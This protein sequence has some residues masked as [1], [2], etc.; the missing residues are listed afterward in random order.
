MMTFREATREVRSSL[1]EEV[2]RVKTEVEKNL[3][4]AETPGP[5]APPPKTDFPG[6]SEADRATEK[7]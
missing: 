1:D 3:T 5:E 7:P 4:E 6:D 2:R